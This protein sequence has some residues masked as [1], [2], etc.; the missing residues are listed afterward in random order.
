VATK[1]TEFER[2]FPDIG[3]ADTLCAWNGCVAVTT[4]GSAASKHTLWRLFRV[5]SFTLAASTGKM[6]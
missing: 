6:R 3:A 1:I 5:E 4:A 2:G